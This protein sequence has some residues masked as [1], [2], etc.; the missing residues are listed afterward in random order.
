MAYQVAECPKRQK[1][2]VYLIASILP[3]LSVALICSVVIDSYHVPRTSE[4]WS[5]SSRYGQTNYI[6][7]KIKNYLFIPVLVKMAEVS[8][9]E[10]LLQANQN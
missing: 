8:N 1:I 2:D 4:V 6:Q 9:I 10:I 3:A 7:Y 5:W